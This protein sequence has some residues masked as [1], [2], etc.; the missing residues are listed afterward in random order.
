MSSAIA[1]INVSMKPLP[2]V[3]TDTRYLHHRS[4]INNLQ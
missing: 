2:I 3:I 4:T 1:T